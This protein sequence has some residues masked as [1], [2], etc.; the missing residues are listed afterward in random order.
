M[1]THLVKKGTRAPEASV[2]RINE[3]KDVVTSH[4]GDQADGSW[5]RGSDCN[6]LP[7]GPFWQETDWVKK[8]LLP[9]LV[10]A[11]PL[12]DSYDVFT[13][14]G[15][16]FARH[17]VE[18]LRG[19][20]Y[21]VGPDLVDGV[22]HIGQWGAGMVNVHTILKQFQWAW[23]DHA[24][25]G[26]AYATPNEQVAAN[27]VIQQRTRSVF[28]LTSVFIITLGL[29]EVWYDRV[30]QEVF[31]KAIPSRIYNP[32]RH[33][34]RVLGV[35]ET[36]RALSKI[37]ELIRTQRPQAHVIFTLSPVPL[38]ATF[39]PVGCLVADSVSKATLR[40]ALDMLM[41]EEPPKTWYWPSYEIVKNTP[42]AYLPDNRHIK[43][44]VVNSIMD[45]FRH[46]FFLK[47]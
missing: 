47:E 46:A 2:R 41:R 39:R 37:R 20:G 8:W 3:T 34:F 30:T 7:S 10:P 36:Y 40:V 17:L 24:L 19:T 11:E 42:E 22:T 31:W 21:K 4:S 6:W 25:G 33:G 5:W 43:P 26:G 28:D 12:F 38:V 23:G 18:Y 15:S 44:N 45:A 9:G 27:A 32:E 29:S 16:C 35:E 1:P 13:A 14:F